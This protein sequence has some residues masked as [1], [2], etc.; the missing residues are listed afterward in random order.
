MNSEIY[1][2]EQTYEQWDLGI[3]ADRRM[4]SEI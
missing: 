3:V 2:L 4:N 1:E